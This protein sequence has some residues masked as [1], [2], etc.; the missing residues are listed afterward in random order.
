[1]VRLA[2][3]PG[4]AAPPEAFHDRLRSGRLSSGG[5]ARPLDG[6]LRLARTLPGSRPRLDGRLSRGCLWT[7]EPRQG[8]D[9]RSGV[10]DDLAPTRWEA[11]TAR[12]GL[13]LRRRRY[14]SRTRRGGAS[15]PP[16]GGVEA[17]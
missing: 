7:G 15:G 5:R 2:A 11:P 12:G 10:P 8:V 17:S 3:V 1:S 16:C 14:P 6:R 9:V 13:M 4:P